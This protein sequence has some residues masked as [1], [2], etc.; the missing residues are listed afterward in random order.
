MTNQFKQYQLAPFLFKALDAEH[1]DTPTPIQEKVIPALL[2]GESVVGQS[3]T[4][5]G[6]THAFL[7]PLL[8]RIDLA[9]DEVQLV[10]TRLRAS[11]PI[12]FTKSPA[13]WPSLSRSCESS[14]TSRHGQEPPGR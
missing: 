5:S 10:I 12:S 2:R 3:Q 11:W 9:K 7:L 14:V 6:K 1:I 13:T 4:G 8:S